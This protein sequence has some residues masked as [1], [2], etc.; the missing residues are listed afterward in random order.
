MLLKSILNRSQ[1]TL[2][3]SLGRE[4]SSVLGIV[5]TNFS[6]IAFVSP[7][8]SFNPTAD[9]PKHICVAISRNHIHSFYTLSNKQAA[10]KS[11]EGVEVL[12]WNLKT[13]LKVTKFSLEYSSQNSHLCNRGKI[14][15]VAD[16]MRWVNS[17]QDKTTC[18][19][20]HQKRRKNW[21]RVT[22]WFMFACCSQ[23]K[24][25]EKLKEHCRLQGPKKLGGEEYIQNCSW[26]C[27]HVTVTRTQIQVKCRLT[28]K[29]LKLPEF[30]ERDFCYSFC[31]VIEENW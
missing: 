29:L 30:K 25:S 20:H 14:P 9:V 24:G 28:L 11:E 17:V 21:E 19:K 2:M 26:R 3:W 27:R 8:C 18:L 16:K 22:T 1:E 31:F 15:K 23:A 7:S 12:N 6:E 10:I 13:T 4:P 5:L